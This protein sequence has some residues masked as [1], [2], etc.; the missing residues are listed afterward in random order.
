MIREAQVK[1]KEP[2]PEMKKKGLVYEVSVVSATI[3]YIGK[4]GRT[5]ER[6]LNKVAVEGTTEKRALHYMCERL[7][8]K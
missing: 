2:N 4:M 5:L 6:R 1:V 7:V 8:I 3:E